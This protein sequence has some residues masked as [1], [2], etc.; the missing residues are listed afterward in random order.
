MTRGKEKIEVEPTALAVDT[1][2]DQDT[3]GWE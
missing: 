2:G 3:L 1:R